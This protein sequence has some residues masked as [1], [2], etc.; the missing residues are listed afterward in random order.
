[1]IQYLPPGKRNSAKETFVLS[2]PDFD[3]QNIMIDERGNVTGIIDWDNVQTLPRFIGYSRFPGWIT[4]DWDPLMYSYPMI[5]DRENS[6][7]ELKRYRARYRATMRE[8]LRGRG[9]S[10]F[11][12]KSHIFE[13]VA[14][15]ARNHICRLEIVNKIVE[16]VFPIQEEYNGIDLIRDVA[17]G[18]LK[19]KDKKKLAL[20]FQALLS[21]PG[22]YM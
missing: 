16:R 17:D 3:S 1:M 18:K 10:I 21:V 4:R 15:A 12:G 7:E 13:A 14:I 5:K 8:L 9:D 11:V 2:L 19:V 22:Y 6:P 20:G